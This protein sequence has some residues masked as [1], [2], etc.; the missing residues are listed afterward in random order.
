MERHEVTTFELV[1]DILC[2]LTLVL[3]ILVMGCATVPESTSVD[4]F[5]DERAVFRDHNDARYA[6]VGTFLP[7]S[8]SLVA[9]AN[10]APAINWDDGTT[11]VIAMQS[12]L[13]R[14]QTWRVGATTTGADVWASAPAGLNA[15]ALRAGVRWMTIT[16]FDSVDA[17]VPICVRL[18][19]T[20]DSPAVTCA[21]ATVNAH[22][23]SAFG[24]TMTLL[25]REPQDQG[26]LA[27]VAVP[28]WV[29]SQSGTVDVAVTVGY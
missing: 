13:G 27:N 5:V 9:V 29:V 8:D 11:P 20:T 10:T 12:G 15:P 6:G 18:G 4:S 1:V 28:V 3:L 23:V 22:P 24:G 7:F 25:M 2:F 19:P 21:Q 14:T 16:H 17:S 26:T